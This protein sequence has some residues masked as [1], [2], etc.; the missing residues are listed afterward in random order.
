M[1]D[2]HD[3]GQAAYELDLLRQQQEEQE[4]LRRVAQNNRDDAE[5]LARAS[6]HDVREVL[7]DTDRLSYQL[8]DEG[9]IA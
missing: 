5:I 9:D 1:S 8:F 3:D 6:G 4:A 7:D 2:W